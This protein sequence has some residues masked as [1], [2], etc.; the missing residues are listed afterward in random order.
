MK[1]LADAFGGAYTEETP[2]EDPEYCSFRVSFDRHSSIFQVL[3]VFPYDLPDPLETAEWMRDGLYSNAL[4]PLDSSLSTMNWSTDRAD[5]LSDHGYLTWPLLSNERSDE[6]RQSLRE[7]SATLEAEFPEFGASAA[8]AQGV[9]LFEPH[10]VRRLVTRY[11]RRWHQHS[12][13]IHRA[14]FDPNSSSFPLLLSV[15]LIRGLHSISAREVEM[16]R[17]MVFLAEEFVYRDPIFM[18][19]QS[20]DSQPLVSDI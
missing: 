5:H 12:P 20:G 3:G 19:L 10:N 2:D 14:S 6:L 17:R 11:F 4:F 13:I 16:A 15:V 18:L 8:L 9:E 1:T 7:M